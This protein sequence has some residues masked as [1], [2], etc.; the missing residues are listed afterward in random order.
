MIVVHHLNNSRSQRILWLLEELELPYEIK[1]YQRQASM[2]APPELKKV[3]PL[4]KAPVIT[5]GDRVVAESGAI[6]EYLVGRYDRNRLLTPLDE[7]EALEC[8]YWLHYAEGSLMPLV[9]MRL[10]F[11]RMGKPP[12]PWLL[13]PIGAAFGN[14]V[15]KGFLD[16]QL[17]THRQF[18][19]QHLT[20][21]PWF[22]GQHLTLADI[23]MSFP[24]QGLAARGGLDGMLATQAWLDKISR[25]PAWQRAIQQGGEL[26]LPD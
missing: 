17:T 24:I 18:I 14:G 4:G 10:I 19:E 13:R 15:R 9:V 6:L 3:H 1:R 7:E 25:R 5:D 20:R 2:L 11:S 26:N 12:V 23:Q 21:P 22:A 16:K 8:R